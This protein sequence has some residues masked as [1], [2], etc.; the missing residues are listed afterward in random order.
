MT[1]KDDINNHSLYAFKH[2]SLVKEGQQIKYNNPNLITSARDLAAS[3]E[4]LPKGA[5][6]SVG[7]FI[8]NEWLHDKE[9]LILLPIQERHRNKSAFYKLSLSK[10]PKKVNF[11]NYS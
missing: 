11:L 9:P 2:I 10:L 8:C 3:L 5:N 1:F 4:I 6:Y 7:F